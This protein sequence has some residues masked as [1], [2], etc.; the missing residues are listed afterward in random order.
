VPPWATGPAL[1][2][3]GAMMMRNLVDIQWGNYGEVEILKIAQFS[4]KTALYSSTCAP[5]LLEK[6]RFVG[7]TT[8]R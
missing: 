4:I 7:E 5:H 6:V 1:I 8:G 3:V 2:T